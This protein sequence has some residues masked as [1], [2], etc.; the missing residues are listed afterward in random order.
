MLDSIATST[1]SADKILSIEAIVSCTLNFILTSELPFNE[2]LKKAQEVGLTEKDPSADLSGAD[3]TRKLLIL[4]REAG[5]KLEKDDSAAL[6]Y[7]ASI[8]L[9][10]LPEGHPA[11]RIKGTENMIIVRSSY[12]TSPVIIQGPGEGAKMAAARILNDILR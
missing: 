4:A 11:L 9:K 7:R 5:V 6:G 2:A 3:A 12:Q 10:N 8:T 1:E